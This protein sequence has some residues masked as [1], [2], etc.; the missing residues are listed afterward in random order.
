MADLQITCEITRDSKKFV[1]EIIDDRKT[2][3][4]TDQDGVVVTISYK[5]GNFDV[6]LPNGWGNWQ[7]S[8]ASAVNSAVDLCATAREQLTADTAYKEMVEYVKKCK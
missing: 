2:A 1:I 8:M 3:T 6:R 4:V 5:S 7:S